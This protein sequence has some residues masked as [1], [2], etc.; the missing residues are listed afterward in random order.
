MYS[1]GNCNHLS[2]TRWLHIKFL[3]LKEYD[4]YP[5]LSISRNNICSINKYY[6]LVFDSKLIETN[7]ILTML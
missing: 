6:S 4:L 2:A 5:T 1:E 3:T 7:A